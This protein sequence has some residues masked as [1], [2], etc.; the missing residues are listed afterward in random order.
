MRDGRT[1]SVGGSRRWLVWYRCYRLQ[2]TGY[3]LAGYQPRR[4]LEYPSITVKLRD[5]A[6]FRTDLHSRRPGARPLDRRDHH[7]DLSDLDLRAGRAGPPQGLRVRAHAEPDARGARGQHRGDR[8]RQGRLRVRVGH[9]RRGRGHDAAPVR[10][11]RGRHGQY[12]R[13]HVSIVR[14]RAPQV[15]ARFHLRGLVPPGSDREGDHA[16][17]ED[18]VPGVADQPD[19]AADRSPGSV[20]AGACARGLRGRGQHLREPVYPAADRLRRGSG[21]PQHDEVPQRPQRQRRRRRRRG[22][23]RAHRVAA[24]HSERRG[25]DSRADG[26]LARAAWDQD[27]ADQNGASQRQC[28]GAGRVPCLTRESEAGSLSRAAVAST[29]RA[30]ETSDVRLRRTDLARARLARPGARAARRRP[31]DGA[32]RESRRRGN[33]DQ[34]SGNHD[35]RVSAGRAASRDRCDGRSGPDLRRH[36]GR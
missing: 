36:R 15:S 11:S 20:R 9:G 18:A 34:P 7:A 17:H 3:Q 28:A 22:E 1:T 33:P 10:R 35:P 14:A 16:V 26:R 23:G 12:I 30:R 21:G 19:T 29:T 27:A 6:R 24:V 32:G 13:R 2:A 25:R 4:S 31:P 8:T 5:N